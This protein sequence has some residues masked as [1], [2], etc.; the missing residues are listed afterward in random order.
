[1]LSGCVLGARL[2]ADALASGARALADRGA[3]GGGELV[4]TL[5]A[6][7][8]G[9]EVDVRAQLDGGS[10]VI[11]VLSTALAVVGFASQLAPGGGRLPAPARFFGAPVL[12]FDRYLQA[13]SL[14]VIRAV[15]V[16]R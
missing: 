2:V 1:M 4:V 15:G 10:P 7:L 8:G 13:L 9:G 3:G 11:G 16:R 14:N 5:P 6:W 12:A